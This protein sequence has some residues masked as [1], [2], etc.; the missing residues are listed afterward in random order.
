LYDVDAARKL[1]PSNV[2]DH[3]DIAVSRMKDTFSNQ[4]QKIVFVFTCAT[5]P[6]HH[7]APLMR[8][9]GKT[10]DGTT[11]FLKDVKRCEEK[12]GIYQPR[13]ASSSLPYSPETHRA[14]LVLRC[15][16]HARPMNE[17]LDDDYQTEVEM[18]RPGTVVPHPTTIQRDLVNIYEHMSDFVR[19]YFLVY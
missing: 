14:L 9:R 12:Q 6:E 13:S 3:Y 17:I 4:R 8:D 11:K 15:A 1:W 7:I 19:N 2:Y 5:H 18:L 16:K 10:G